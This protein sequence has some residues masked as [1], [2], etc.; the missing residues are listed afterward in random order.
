MLRPAYDGSVGLDNLA[1]AVVVSI[2][3]AEAIPP[4]PQ[5]TLHHVGGMCRPPHFSA[6]T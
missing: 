4:P 6:G 5:F 1:K 2:L 3:A